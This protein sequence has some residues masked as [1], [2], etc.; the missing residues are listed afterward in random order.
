MQGMAEKAEELQ[1][2]VQRVQQ[3]KDDAEVRPAFSLILLGHRR[4]ES[5]L[6]HVFINLKH[7]RFA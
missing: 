1:K 4:N 6:D 5:G 2:E 7:S 3:E